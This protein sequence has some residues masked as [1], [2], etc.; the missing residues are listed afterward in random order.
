[1]RAHFKHVRSKSFTL[2]SNGFWPLKLFFE[3]L[4]VHQNS[5]SQNGSSLWNVEVHFLT[6]S[7]IPESVRRDSRA[8]LLA[9]TFA[10]PGLGRKPKAKVVTQHVIIVVLI[11]L[12]ISWTLLCLRALSFCLLIG[13]FLKFG[14]CRCIYLHA[15]FSRN[16]GKIYIQLGVSYNSFHSCEIIY[17]F[18]VSNYVTF[19]FMIRIIAHIKLLIDA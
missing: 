15:R 18:L 7:Y 14:S 19:N 4:E 1:M 16:I 9:R 8:S 10:S 17:I 5:N 12:I 3:N 13:K 11:F 2:Q 6:L